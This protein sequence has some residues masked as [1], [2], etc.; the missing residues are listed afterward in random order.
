MG[1]I[2]W[3]IIIAVIIAV[4]YVPIDAKYELWFWESKYGTEFEVRIMGIKL[5]LPFPEKDIEEEKKEKKESKSSD[6]E[7]SSE[8]IKDGIFAFKDYFKELKMPI[9]RLWKYLLK[10]VI[11]IKNIELDFDF[12][13]E[14]PMITGIMNGVFYGTV[15][16]ILGILHRNVKVQ[17]WNIQI[18]PDFYNQKTDVRFSCILRT[19]VAYII[20][21]AFK[22]LVI[23]VKYK[24]ITK[25]RK[26]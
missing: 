23:L 19:R 24:S 6:K 12:G 10:R 25:R 1:F 26:G 18:T 20:G 11:V 16:N 4:L 17:K 7:I 15:Y 9:G 8:K 14:D 2:I 3:G 22:G 5:K 21:I 13:F